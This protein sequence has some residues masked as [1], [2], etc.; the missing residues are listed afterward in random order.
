MMENSSLRVSGRM[1]TPSHICLMKDIY[2]ISLTNKYKETKQE[3]ASSGPEILP[4]HF[5]GGRLVGG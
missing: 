4:E 2:F 3:Y 1:E 5:R